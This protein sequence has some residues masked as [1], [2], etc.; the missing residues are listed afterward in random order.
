MSDGQ[1]HLHLPAPQGVGSIVLHSLDGRPATAFYAATV[2]E[3]DQ[4]KAKLARLP[5]VTEGGNSFDVLPL[6][7]LPDVLKMMRDQPEPS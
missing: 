3:A 6:M 7:Q 2:D 1:S 5:G 4:A